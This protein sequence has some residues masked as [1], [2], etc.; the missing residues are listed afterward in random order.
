MNSEAQNA[1]DLVHFLIIFSTATE[2][3]EI[4]SPA[5]RKAKGKNMLL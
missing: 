1:L 2:V 5:P 4:A 3:T